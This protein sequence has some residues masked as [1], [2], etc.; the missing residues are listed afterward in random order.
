MSTGIGRSALRQRRFISRTSSS[1][2]SATIWPR[3]CGYA[4]ERDLH[5]R[6]C[7]SQRSVSSEHCCT[8][9]FKRS[10]AVD[11]RRMVRIGRGMRQ[12][13]KPGAVSQE[14]RGGDDGVMA[15]ITGG[16][17]TS[18]ISCSPNSC[19]SSRPFSIREKYSRA[20]H[21]NARN[22]YSSRPTPQP[23]PE[24]AHELHGGRRVE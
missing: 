5:N 6:D 3:S 20:F 1:P 2:C 23:R 19:F 7:R 14:G 9:N 4:S 21:A 18:S 15:S 11:A 22:R 12:K 13:F 8:V 10:R 16:L 17:R 24:L